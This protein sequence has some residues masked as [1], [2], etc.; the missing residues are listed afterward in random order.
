MANEVVIKVNA[1]TAKAQSSLKNLGDSVQK[2]GKLAMG[3]G[4]AIGA[5]G[6]ASLKSFAGAGDQIQKMA[7][8]T[9]FSTESLSEL[10]VAA[11]LSGTSLDGFENAARRMFRTI[12]DAERD[13]MT[14]VDALGAL[15]LT[16]AELINLHPEEAFH[17]IAFALADLETHAMKSAKASEI[18]GRQGTMLLPML[19][20]GAEG[21]AE[22]SKKAH[23]LGVIWDQ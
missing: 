5:I 10:R 16:S 14:A 12:S 7:I 6:A 17:K 18:F 22:L 9:G 13:M 20:D 23:E 15:G 11:E 19:E 3:A 2:L 8:R 4:L 1:N 21:F